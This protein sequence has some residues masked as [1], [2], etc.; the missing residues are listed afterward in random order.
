M[1]SIDLQIVSLVVSIGGFAVSIGILYYAYLRFIEVTKQL[2]TATKQLDIGNKQL[3]IATKQM[4]STHDWNR[5][6]AT[7][8]VLIGNVTGDMAAPRRQLEGHGLAE[9]GVKGLGVKPYDR[10]QTYATVLSKLDD[11]EKPEFELAVKTLFNVF[12]I[13]A[14]GMKHH[15]MDQQITSDYLSLIWTEYYRWGLPF[16]EEMRLTTHDRGVYIEMEQWAVRWRREMDLALI[17]PGMP[18]TG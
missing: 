14:V 7:L 1:S 3:E 2:E 8:D 15:V 6:K 17:T 13:V 9:G 12:E 11:A 10:K 5:R 4:A 18:P 16:I